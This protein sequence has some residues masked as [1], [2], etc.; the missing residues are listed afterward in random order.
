MI[1]GSS[2][3]ELAEGALLGIEEG[4]SSNLSRKRKLQIHEDQEKERVND[5]EEKMEII[6]KGRRERWDEEGIE[7]RAR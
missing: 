3:S 6:Y 7:S 1:D 4:D 2:T 5:G